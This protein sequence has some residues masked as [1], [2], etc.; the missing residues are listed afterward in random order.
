MLSKDT[1]LID[2]PYLSI[3]K[4]SNRMVFLWLLWF[5]RETKA[6]ETGLPALIVIESKVTNL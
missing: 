2:V 1:N 6:N 5:S 3:K 4:G